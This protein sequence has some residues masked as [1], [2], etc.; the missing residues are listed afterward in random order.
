MFC[1][2]VA[3]VGDPIARFRPGSV[4]YNTNTRACTMITPACSGILPSNN[5]LKC[6]FSPNPLCT[7]QTN[8]ACPSSHCDSK[9]VTCATVSATDS[10]QC[11]VLGA[12]N[13]YA[14]VE[15]NPTTTDC[16]QIKPA[17]TNV[18]TTQLILYQR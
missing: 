15:F 11:E 2:G 3:F 10:R 13:G 1:G 7:F 17:C 18:A 9:D 12:R 6:D 16:K 4:T 14:Q 5:Y 8:K